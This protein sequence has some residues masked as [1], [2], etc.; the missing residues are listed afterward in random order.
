MRFSLSVQNIS[1][2]KKLDIA[3]AVVGGVLLIFTIGVFVWSIQFLVDTV[4]TA[5]DIQTESETSVSFRLDALPGLGI[6]VEEKVVPN[7][8]ATTTPAPQ[9]QP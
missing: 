3:F 8:P 4:N 1:R 6:S 9:V 2:H 7:I 5:L